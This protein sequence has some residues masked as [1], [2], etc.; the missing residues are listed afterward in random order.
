MAYGNVGNNFLQVF[1]FQ[2]VVMTEQVLAV[3]I[4]AY[5]QI[6]KYRRRGRRKEGRRC[7][8][9]KQEQEQKIT[10]RHSRRRST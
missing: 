4:V 10:K 7:M 3:V 1:E 9:M 6:N 8:L 2:Q 5:L